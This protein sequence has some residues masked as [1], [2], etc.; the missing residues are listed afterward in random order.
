[1]FKKRWS[2]FSINRIL[3]Q[4]TGMLLVLNLGVPEALPAG[5]SELSDTNRPL[6]A[7]PSPLLI[8][9]NSLPL[10]SRGT[11]FFHA[12]YEFKKNWEAPVSQFRGNL[13]RFGVLRFDFYLSE[14]VSLQ[15]RGVVNQY[16]DAWRPNQSRLPNV[17]FNAANDVGDFSITTLAYLIP[18]GFYHPAFGLRVEAKLPNTNQ[19]NGLGTNTT[20]IKLSVL[21]SKRLGSFNLYSDMGVGI[22]SAPRQL[23]EQNDVLLYGFGGS[24]KVGRNML[25][26][27]ELNGFLSTR[28]NVPLGTEDRGQARLGMVWRFSQ[29]AVEIFPQYGLTHRDGSLGIAAGLSWQLNFL[30]GEN[31]PLK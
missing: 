13:H 3:F 27:G 11:V 2:Y 24:V 28:Q 30:N 10:M 21:T 6:T 1:M 5:K 9:T 23:N 12:G 26:A 14:R 18:D 17:S 4:L 25:L 16:L 31:N 7:P 15:V 19:N 20:D 29:L 22:L 8:Q